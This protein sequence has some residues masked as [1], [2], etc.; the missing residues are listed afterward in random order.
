MPPAPT[1]A[2]PT[3]SPTKAS[4]ITSGTEPPGPRQRN[5]NSATLA[6]T[7]GD[8]LTATG[9]DANDNTLTIAVPLADFTNLTLTPGTT[10]DFD[11]YSTGTSGNQTAYDSL[12][13]QSE[14][15]SGTYSSTLQYNSTVLDSYT[16]QSVPEPASLAVLAVT[17]LLL[18]EAEKRAE[19]VGTFEGK[20]VLRGEAYA[21]KDYVEAVGVLRW[22][23]SCGDRGAGLAQLA[24]TGN[25]ANTPVTYGSPQPGTSALATQTINTSFGDNTSS[26][27]HLNGSELDAAYG[28]VSGGYLYLFISGNLQDNGN[29]LDIWIDDGRAGQNVLNAPT[30]A[31]NMHNENGSIFSSG[32]NATYAL[33]LNTTDVTP[34][35]N[36]NFFVDQYNLVGT[37]NATFLGQFGLT[38]GV[39]NSKEAGST[40]SAILAAVTN[41]NTLGV[42]G[43]ANGG[44]AIQ[45]N[46]QSVA[47]GF[48]FGIP[49]ASLGNPTGNIEVL[50]GINGSGDSGFCNQFL[51]GLEANTVSIKK[52]PNSATNPYYLTN[53]EFTFANT[54]GE[55]FT[56]PNTVLAN[57]IWLPTGDGNWSDT[58]NWSNGVVPNGVGASA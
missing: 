35:T 7:Q 21:A 47:T 22:C 53:T 46:A 31:G 2:S 18:M 54:P 27:G 28:T 4:T 39:G 16:I 23:D 45:A 33:E 8:S 9:G 14:T 29:I 36:G 43:D 55:F 52:G 34:N 58:T 40:E 42:V 24:I 19:K 37:P 56:V 5:V 30:G 10:I 3:P 48:E 12:A 11:I 17:G 51:P 15:Q 38:G 13:N 20:N 1:A 57:G 26:T 25:L 32:F 44:A 50:A 49:L 6:G 41:T